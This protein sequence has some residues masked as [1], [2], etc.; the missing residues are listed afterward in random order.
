MRE[1]KLFTSA[2]ADLF[3]PIESPRYV[4][5][6]KY[7]K[8]YRY[9]CALACP[10][11]LGTKQE[12]V[13]LF[14]DNLKKTLGKMEIVYTRSTKGNAFLKRCRRKAYITENNRIVE[15]TFGNY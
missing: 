13:R 9:K 7:G 3:S 14:A 6:P 4:L 12:N 11:V 8:V 2:V 5:I 1:Q 15:E 10:S